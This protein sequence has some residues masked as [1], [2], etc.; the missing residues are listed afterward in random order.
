MEHGAANGQDILMEQRT[1]KRHARSTNIRDPLTPA[2]GSLSFTLCPGTLC[3]PPAGP[4]TKWTSAIISLLNMTEFLQ[5]Q[6]LLSRVQLD[7]KTCVFVEMFF[8]HWIS[9]QTQTDRKDPRVKPKL[10]SS[11]WV[12]FWT[13]I[14]EQWKT[15]GVSKLPECRFK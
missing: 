10:A 11:T 6:C 1:D 3:V 4:T 14:T 9:F 5:K 12:P 2:E 8:L 7:K 13:P 15:S